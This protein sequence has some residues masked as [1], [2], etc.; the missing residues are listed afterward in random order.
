VPELW[1]GKSFPSL[2]PLSGYV[3]DL[4]ARLG[5]LQRWYEEGQPA[6]FWI[7]GFFFT[8]AFTTASL[9]NYARKLKLPIDTV[10]FDFETLS[11]G[12]EAITQA[13]EDGVYIYGL[14]LEGCAW[15]ADARLLRESFPKQ[16]FCSAPVLW[17]RPKQT[18]DFVE[19]DHYNCPVY[20]TGER[21]GTLAT[22]GHSTNFLMYIKMPSSEPEYHWT[23]RGV[24][25]LCSLSD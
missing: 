9:Q 20:R 21:R 2:K 14:Y 23:M 4:L 13:P 16:L 6:S 7:S 22:T 5:M 1:K 11:E 3:E 19:F 8:P 17:L 12:H 24:C 15:D 18:Q 25:M 10:G